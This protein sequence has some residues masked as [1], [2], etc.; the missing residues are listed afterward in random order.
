MIKKLKKYIDLKNFLGIIN[1]INFINE[2][3]GETNYEI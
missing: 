2:M 1:S 3:G